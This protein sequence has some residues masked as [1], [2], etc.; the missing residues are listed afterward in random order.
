[1][2]ALYVTSRYAPSCCLYVAPSHKDFSASDFLSQRPSATSSVDA[3]VASDRQVSCLH[4][5]LGSTGRGCCILTTP[6]LSSRRCSF[7]LRRL[8]T[9]RHHRPRGCSPSS[10]AR[11]INDSV[12]SAFR[13]MTRTIP[14]LSLTGACGRRSINR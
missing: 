14:V 12:I 7:L 2:I 3:R 10:P 11:H 1:M 6:R 4:E 9:L 8:R 5:L 13:R